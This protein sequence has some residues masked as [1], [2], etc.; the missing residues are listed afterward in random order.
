[1]KRRRCVAFVPSE[2]FDRAPCPRARIGR[3][4][5][6]GASTARRRATAEWILCP[7]FAAANDIF[8]SAH[9]EAACGIVLGLLNNQKLVDDETASREMAAIAGKY[10]ANWRVNSSKE[11]K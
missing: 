2:P 8:C 6:R 5:S 9:R 11:A 10:F 3:A 7:T 1:M 4:K